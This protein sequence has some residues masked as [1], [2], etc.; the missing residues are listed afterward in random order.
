MG[1]AIEIGMRKAVLESRLIAIP[2]PIVE[3][4]MDLKIGT[5]PEEK[6]V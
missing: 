4:L 6:P 1:G 2:I 3:L 5:C